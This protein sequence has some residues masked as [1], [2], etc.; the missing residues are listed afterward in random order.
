[1]SSAS[2]ARTARSTDDE[3]V[4]LLAGKR[5]V[6]RRCRAASARSPLAADILVEDG[7]P[8]A[9]AARGL[10]PRSCCAR[11]P[12]LVIV[13]V[14]PFGQTGPHAAWRADEHRVASPW[15]G[16]MS[17]TGVAERAPLVNGG[18]QAQ[19]LGGTERLRRRAHRATTAR[20]CRARATGSTSPSRS[21]PPACS[22]STG[23]GTAYDEPVRPAQLGNHVRAVWGIYPCA[24]GYAGVCCLERQIPALFALL[25]DP[26]LA[27]ERFRDPISA[28][29]HDDELRRHHVRAGSRTAPRP[30]CSTSAPHKVPFG[31]V[32]TPADLL[33]S[34]EPRGA[35][36][37]RRRRE[38]DG[39]RT[40]AR[41]GRSPASRWRAR[42]PARTRRRHRRRPRR[43]ARGAR[44]EAAAARGVRVARPDDDV[45]RPL[46][47]ARCSPRWAP[48]SSRSSRPRAW[49]NIRT[50]HPPAGRRRPVELGLLLQRLQPRQEVAHARPRP[51]RA[52]ASCSSARAPSATCVIENY[53]ADVLD[54][55][56]LG[57]DVL[58]AA[59]RGHRRS[60]AWPASARPAPNATTSASARSSR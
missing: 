54:K 4:Y 18:S 21:A 59:P 51:G 42:R 9:L 49:D 8:G 16:I 29:T 17:L 24:D 35:R 52:A 58:R 36:L 22:S 19:Y 32:L 10:D 6:A 43:L 40:R 30:R 50:L 1:M 39:R 53:R 14:T 47:H 26:E 55:L 5:R 37:L 28:S 23:R 25:G 38:P 13:S 11:Q 45:G 2:R 34:H 15:A 12:A 46:R 3:A 33:A 20:S 7:T 27:D 31:A 56:G 41:A 60:S 44:D 48:R 57:Y